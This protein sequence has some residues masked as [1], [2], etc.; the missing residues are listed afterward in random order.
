MEN[1]EKNWIAILKVV[2]PTSPALLGVWLA[3]SVGQTYANAEKTR[4]E[5]E[6]I[7]VAVENTEHDL[8]Q[9][10]GTALPRI[11]TRNV[12]NQENLIGSSC[13]IRGMLTIE[14]LGVVPIAV[15]EIVLFDVA[16]DTNKFPKDAMTDSVNLSY[17]NLVVDGNSDYASVS[18]H[19]LHTFDIRLAPKAKSFHSYAL[20]IPH[21]D[22]SIVG[23]HASVTANTV[24]CASKSESSKGVPCF[25]DQE[26]QI[27]KNNFYKDFASTKIANRCS[28]S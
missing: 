11:G 22:S 26:P 25:S 14:N 23:V 9:L 10:R 1:R 24:T 12:I 8:A 18:K 16:L 20:A 13:F 3:Y 2:I 19:D 15:S 6:S 28:G 7:K 27:L 17:S 4:A 21:T 5:T